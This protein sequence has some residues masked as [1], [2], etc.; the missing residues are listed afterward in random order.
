MMFLQVMI[1]NVRGVFS[2]FC[3]LQRIFRLVCI[4]LVVQKQALGEVES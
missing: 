3:V 4:L 1:G 2:R